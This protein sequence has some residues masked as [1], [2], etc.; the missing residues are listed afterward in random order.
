[1]P[2]PAKRRTALYCTVISTGQLAIVRMPEH[3]VTW[4]TIRREIHAS[5]RRKHGILAKDVHDIECLAG[6]VDGDTDGGH[7]MR[8]CERGFSGD[9]TTLKGFA[10][11]AWDNEAA[12]FKLVRQAI[13]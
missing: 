3:F 11:H 6:A 10:L 7:G 1:M 13:S 8:L 12:T 9:Q 5:V 4:A 2:Q